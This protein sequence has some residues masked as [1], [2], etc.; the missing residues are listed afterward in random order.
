MH[1]ANK[2]IENKIAAMQ[3]TLLEDVQARKQIQENFS[4]RYYMV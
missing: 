4:Q 2:E 1:H 3:E